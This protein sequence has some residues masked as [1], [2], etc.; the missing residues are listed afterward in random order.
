MKGFKKL[1]DFFKDQKL[2]LFEKEAVWILTNKEQIIWIIGHRMDDRCRIE[3]NEKRL[4]KIT[5]K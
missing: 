5:V 1:S 3:G 2:S 4:V